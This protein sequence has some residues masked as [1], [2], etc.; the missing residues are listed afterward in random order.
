M[1]ATTVPFSMVCA[2]GQRYHPALVAQAIATLDELFPGRINV[3]LGSGEALNEC[4]TGEG[5]PSK[6]DRNERLRICAQIIRQLLAGEEVT[7]R[8][9]INV[10]KAKLYTLPKSKPLLLCAAISAETA[11]WAASWADGLLTTNEAAQPALLKKIAA[12]RNGG[13]NGKPVYVQFAFSYA[14]DRHSAEQGAFDQWRSNILPKEKLAGLRQVEEF[15]AAAEA[16]SLQEVLDAIPVFTSMDHL[17][18]EV[19]K[20]KST[21]VERIVLHNICRP[22]HEFLEDFASFNKRK[23]SL[24]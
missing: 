17:M 24:R 1:Q 9:M 18:E 10:E 8:G 6:T 20:L 5:W 19:N 13:G 7:H 21:G 14:R 3:E 12:F 23:D 11:Q 16:V 4:I 2:P 15:D 22:H